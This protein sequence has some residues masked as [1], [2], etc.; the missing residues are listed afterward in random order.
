MTSS[1]EAAVSPDAMREV[2]RTAI[3][4]DGPSIMERLNGEPSQD[5]A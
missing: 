2:G 1:G 3:V 5:V 4:P